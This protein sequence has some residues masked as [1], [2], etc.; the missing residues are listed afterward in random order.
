VEQTVVRYAEK[1][2]VQ[3]QQW[4]CVL[5]LRYRYRS[6]QDRMGACLGLRFPDR[7]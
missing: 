5:I 3:V 1:D 4:E 6:G 2:Q 7:M